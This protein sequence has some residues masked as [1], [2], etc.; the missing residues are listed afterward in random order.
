M[1]RWILSNAELSGTAARLARLPLEFVSDSDTLFQRRGSIYRIALLVPL[2]G[3]VGLW[4]PS[5]I[6]SAQLAVEELNQ[7]IGIGGRQVELIMVDAAMEAR[8]PVEE[9]VN[10]L[11]EAGAIDA[12]VGMH[13][14]A[15]RQRLS[16]VVQ[17]RV[18]YIYTPLYEGGETTRGI[19]TIGETPGFYLGPAMDYLHSK[20][21]V[22]RWALVGNDY[23]WPRISHVFA[24]EKVKALDTEL[25]Y[26]RY[27]P[28]GFGD[29]RAVLNELEQSRAEAVLLSM[30]GQDAVL[31]N[32][33]FGKMELHDKMVRLA[34]AMEE[35]G[36]LA[37][38]A[39][40]L[41]RM[42]SSASYFGV[43]QTEANAAF[44]EKYYNLHGDTAPLLNAFG[45]SV[46]EGVHFLCSLMTSF[47]DDWRRLDA[48]TVRSITYPSA[49]WQRHGERVKDTMPIYL[50][51]A[52]GVQFQII[53]P[54]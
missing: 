37:S 9:A 44:R 1:D 10:D 2:C 4:S 25:V 20:Y 41:K 8:I 50:A 39:R 46:Y 28:F 14:S 27:L 49:R 22:R 21:H 3:S 30:V 52:E 18:P 43:V 26:E 7:R 13:I 31:F 34:C 6:A 35:N 53:K 40:G 12:I 54:L 16:K 42:Y 47:A 48:R 19:F 29:M 5:C 51:R 33:G 11:I 45:Q 32:R 38:G 17:Q 24:K 23:V 15:V 36:L